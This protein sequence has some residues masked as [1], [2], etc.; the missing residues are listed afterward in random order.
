MYS[1]LSSLLCRMLAEL[2]A[3]ND[4]KIFSDFLCLFVVVYHSGLVLVIL[5]RGPSLYL[6]IICL[7]LN[8]KVIL[9]SYL[10]VLTSCFSSLSHLNIWIFW[11]GVLK[12]VHHHRLYGFIFLCKPNYLTFFFSF[13]IFYSKACETLTTSLIH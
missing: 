2:L 7:C 12:Y 8:P 4:G 9:N 11:L 13:L 3:T 10:T 6:L 1:N 5:M